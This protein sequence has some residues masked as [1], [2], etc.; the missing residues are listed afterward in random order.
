MTGQRASDTAE[1][2]PESTVSYS[3]KELL[4]EQTTLLRTIDSKVDSKVDKADL[5]PI[6]MRL[7]DHHGRIVTLEDERTA[8][9]S[10]AGVRAR[11]RQKL[12]LV[13]TA[14]VVPLVVAV[15]LI[16]LR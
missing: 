16:V 8:D 14:I 2:T 3:V 10:A 11:F 9:Q 6:L 5:V 13:T 15:L 1:V 4:A 7:D 12:W